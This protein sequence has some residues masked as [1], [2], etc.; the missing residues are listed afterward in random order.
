MNQV[1]ELGLLHACLKAVIHPDD[2][3]ALVAALRSELFGISDASLYRF[4]KAGGAFSYFSEVPGSLSTNDRRAF[5]DTFERLSSYRRWLDVLP[6]VSAVE[7]IIDDSGLMA[8]AAIRQ[9]GDVD[10]GSLG[11]AVEL[12][13]S[14]QA[15]AWSKAQMVEHVGELVRAEEKYDGISARSRVRPAVRVMNLHKVK[16]MEAPV[17][18]LAD[19]YGDSTGRPAGFHIDRSGD[20]VV[21]YMAVDKKLKSR[22]GSEPVARPAGWEAIQEKESA[23]LRAEELRLRYVAATR[24][25]SALVV[26][27]PEKSKRSNPWRY[28]LDYIPEGGKIPD[29]GPQSAPTP[30]KVT[31]TADEISESLKDVEARMGA[32]FEPTY[33]ILGAKEYAL[34]GEGVEAAVEIPGA[35]DAAAPDLSA[36]DGCYGVE[37]GTAIHSLLQVVAD[38]PGADLERA[39]EAALD[40]NGL[41]PS[42]SGVAVETVKNV[43][44]SEIWERAAESESRLAETPFC[45]L[46]EDPGSLPTLIRGSIDLVFKEGDG[47]VLVDYKTDSLKGTTTE[48]LAGVYTPQ[49]SV[50]ARAWEMCTGEPVK[51]A[52]LYFTSA[53]G[54]VEVSRV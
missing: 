36:V 24:A 49:L 25:A 29:P 50:Y 13:R 52:G 48:E 4:K 27:R 32:M 46:V 28:F 10:A 21:G 12:L 35:G 45:V 14:S 43:T 1:E 20:R 30:G 3:V 18:F 7:K 23:F 2:P 51:E 47:W 40:E 9:G 26:T 31:I 16:G 42:L 54:Y 19:L 11:K 53:E 33:R 41:D 34:A 6:P 17:V 8:R 5:R 22:Y 15:D 39:A 44:R 37:W 38:N